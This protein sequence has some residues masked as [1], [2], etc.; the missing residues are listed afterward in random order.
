MWPKISQ[1]WLYT[2]AITPNTFTIL[3]SMSSALLYFSNFL[4]CWEIW[5]E[6]NDF[7]PVQHDRIWC[8]YLTFYCVILH[9]HFIVLSLCNNKLWPLQGREMLNSTSDDKGILF[10]LFVVNRRVGLLFTAFHQIHK[11][12]SMYTFLR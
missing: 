12:P 7:F 3:I 11:K 4:C 8:T 6:L 2:I 5:L 1:L 10:R 9:I